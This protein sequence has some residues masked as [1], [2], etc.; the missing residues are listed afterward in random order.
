MALSFWEL[1]SLTTKAD[2]YVWADKDDIWDKD[3]LIIAIKC[4]KKSNMINLRF[5]VHQIA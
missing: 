5:I 3:K 2:Y 1:L 4:L